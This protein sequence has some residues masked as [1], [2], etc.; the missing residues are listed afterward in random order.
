M[1]IELNKGVITLE[2][3]FPSRS[4]DEDESVFYLTF[5]LKEVKKLFD[6][7]NVI[8]G[9]EAKLIEKIQSHYETYSSLKLYQSFL[10]NRY[11]H[12]ALNEG[13]PMVDG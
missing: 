7:Y 12:G 11:I 6:Y 5:P 4:I 9:D 13:V 1:K 3:Y 10:A 8:H 2:H